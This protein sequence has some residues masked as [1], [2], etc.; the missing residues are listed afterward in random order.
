MTVERDH[1]AEG[2]SV[3]THLVDIADVGRTQV[4]M[5]DEPVD[6]RRLAYAGITAEQGDFAL[7]QVV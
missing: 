6:E 2:G 5:G 1:L 4:G 7:E 3:H